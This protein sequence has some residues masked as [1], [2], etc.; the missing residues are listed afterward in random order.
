MEKVRICSTLLQWDLGEDYGYQST[1][2]LGTRTSEI[3]QSPLVL[4]FAASLCRP[5]DVLCL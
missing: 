2:A 3:S 4:A 1:H 5:N